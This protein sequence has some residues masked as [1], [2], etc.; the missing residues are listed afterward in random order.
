M[1]GFFP[2]TTL[3]VRMTNKNRMTN[4]TSNG[5]GKCGGPSTSVGMTTYLCVGYG[6]DDDLFVRGQRMG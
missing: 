3:R 2:F 6:W 4:K 1:R 5:K